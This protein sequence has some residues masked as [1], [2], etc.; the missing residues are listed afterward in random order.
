MTY[1]IAMCQLNYGRLSYNFN[2]IKVTNKFAER[3][4][5]IREERGVFQRQL[6]EA[7]GSTHVCI[8]N[9][10][11][12]PRNPS[13]DDIIAIAMFFNVTTDYLLGLTDL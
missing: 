8:S 2:M 9:W 3:L 12:G 6:A 11:A 4:R 7:L 13:L 1:H 10:E 5:E